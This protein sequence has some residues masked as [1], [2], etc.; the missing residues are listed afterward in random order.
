MTQPTERQIEVLRHVGRGLTNQETAERL[1]LSI[2]TVKAHLQNMFDA[3][4][5]KNA[6]HA[7]TLG[8]EQ[9]W[10]LPLPDACPE[11]V[12]P[13]NGMS[14]LDCSACWEL[15]AESTKEGETP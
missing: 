14:C 1:L 3:I 9:G 2:H 4:G 12:H 8:Y 7:V 11:G 5:A 13:H 6:P 15:R 10:L